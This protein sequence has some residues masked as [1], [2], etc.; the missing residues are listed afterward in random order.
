[1]RYIILLI[2]EFILQFLLI[3]ISNQPQLDGTTAAFCAI[4]MHMPNPLCFL[5][6]GPT[7]ECQV[8]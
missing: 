5:Q 2:K 7:V 8:N 4:K 3:H 1:M 6:D